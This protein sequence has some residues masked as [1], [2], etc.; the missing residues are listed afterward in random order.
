MADPQAQRYQLRNCHSRGV[1]EG[2]DVERLLWQPTAGCDVTQLPH[3]SEPV[4]RSALDDGGKDRVD[5]IGMPFASPDA[6]GD[7]LVDG[8]VCDDISPQQSQ[9]PSRPDSDCVAY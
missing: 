1:I 2:S 3:E 8:L 7:D 9:V 4:P 6:F 5:V